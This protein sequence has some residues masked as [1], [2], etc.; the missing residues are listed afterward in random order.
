MFN[1]LVAAAARLGLRTSARA[2]SSINGQIYAVCRCRLKF[3]A[4]PFLR[5]LGALWAAN[6]QCGKGKTATTKRA[7]SVWI[8][9]SASAAAPASDSEFSGPHRK[10]CSTTRRNSRAKL[11]PPDNGRI[12]PR[13]SII[14]I[15]IIIT[16]MIMIRLLLL[17]LLLCL[18][19]AHN[20]NICFHKLYS[21]F[22]WRQT[23][24]E[25]SCNRARMQPTTTIEP[26]RGFHREHSL[27]LWVAQSLLAC[28]RDLSTEV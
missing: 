24:C 23:N 15:I 4:V 10:N 11:L 6:E 8:Y 27:L 17:F 16:I 7:C 14:V 2:A 1:N 19:R 20:S 18:R 3:F 21:R 28:Y 9:R 22:K 26:R 13:A 25:H 12:R 5:S